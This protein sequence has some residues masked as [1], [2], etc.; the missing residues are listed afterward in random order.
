MTPVRF[1]QLLREARE[2][3]GLTTEQLS[4]ETHIP[5]GH[6]EA[7]ETGRLHAVPGAMYR[8]A[9][10]RAYAEGV[11]LDPHYVLAELKIAE[12]RPDDVQ[13]TETALVHIN[14][15]A[16]PPQAAASP[17][18][19]RVARAIVVLLLGAGALLWEDSEIPTLNI[20]P[21]AT[22][23]PALDPATVFDEAVRLA[24]P[25]PAAPTL[26]RA[27]FDPRIAANGK[28]WPSDGRLDEG[29]LVVHSTPRGARV[30]VN[31]VGWGVTPVAIRY[32]PLGTLRVRIGKTDYRV[33]ERTVHLTHEA[34]TSTLRVTLPEVVRRRAAAAPAATGDMLVVTS[35]PAGARVTVNGIGWGTTPLSIRHLPAGAQRVR[36]VKEQFRSEERVV[37]IREGRPG[38]LAVVLKPV[39]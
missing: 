38:R 33:Q 4:R 9:E 2:L 1:G 15:A 11:G 26:K 32:L 13:G 28:R 27:L 16:A 25:P 23:L 37:D 34:P 5:I 3:R 18:G 22:A 36:I 6:I 14:R 10:A 29:V 19:T 12:H 17:H 35:T 8:R 20:E 24:E 31:G 39:S 21:A 30:T 7:L